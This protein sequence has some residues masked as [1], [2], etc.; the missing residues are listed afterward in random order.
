MVFG[1][2]AGQAAAKCPQLEPKRRFE[3]CTPTW[4]GCFLEVGPLKLTA[5][6]EKRRHVL[7]LFVEP[8]KLVVLLG[9]SLS[10]PPKEMGNLKQRYTHMLSFG[11]LF[12]F[13]RIKP[14][15]VVNCPI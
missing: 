8:P 1:R 11:P 6:K 15:V 3:R 2:V 14:E 4:G 7:F 10:E 9:V 5:Y 12:G 13:S